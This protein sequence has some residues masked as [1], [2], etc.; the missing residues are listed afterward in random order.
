MHNLKDPNSRPGRWKIKL[1]EYDY[2][3]IYKPGK[4]NSN[5]DAL[6][7]NPCDILNKGIEGALSLSSGE[8]AAASAGPSPAIGLTGMV[9]ALADK[10]LSSEE[11]EN[12]V[13]HVFLSRGVLDATN[14]EMN[15]DEL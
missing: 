5:A 3:I 14:E 10:D 4:I 1:S 6:S 12:L 13:E 9:C 2:D 8:W 11:L 15:C 7:S